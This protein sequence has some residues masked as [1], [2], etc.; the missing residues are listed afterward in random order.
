MSLQQNNPGRR[1]PFVIL[2]ALIVLLIAG[3][4]AYRFAIRTIE[5]RI[6]TAIG[7]QGE[8]KELRVSPAGIE[9]TGLRIRAS[10]GGEKN[11][12]WPAEDEF[13]ADRVLVVPSLF[14]LLRSRVI[15]DVIRVEGAYVSMLRARDGKMRILPSRLETGPSSSASSKPE[16][17]TVSAPATPPTPAPSTDSAS[18]TTPV[19]INSIELTNGSIDFF[20]ATIRKT[21]V[22]QRLEQINAQ[23]GKISFP[24]LAGQSEIRFQAVHKGVQR[25][26]KISVEGSVELATRDSGITTVLRDV[27]MLSL[28]PYL[29]KGSDAGI[30]KGSLD[31]E[32]NSSIKQGMLYAPGSLAL[33]DLELASS[34]ATV[35]GIPRKLV[36]AMMKNKKGK[37]SVNFVLTGDINDPEYSLNENLS[38]RI[39]AALA[40]KLGVSVEG[41]AKGLGELGGATAES[42]GKALARPR[43]K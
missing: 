2:V 21:P 31:F 6:M 25:D 3:F 16:S 5:A 22:K 33:S 12:S 18:S 28:Q 24:D 32:L 39:A 27:D 26:G 35:L 37:I 20:D 17:T 8:V 7:P 13:R 30:R 36:T 9:I 41:L 29:V 14:D 15:L 42:I 34:S 43:K 40:G 23:I 38:T 19:T 11:A 10:D 1:W 4:A